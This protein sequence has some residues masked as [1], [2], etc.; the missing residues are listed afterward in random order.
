MSH[1]LALHTSLQLGDSPTSTPVALARLLVSKHQSLGKLK[2]QLLQVPELRDV[3]VP[4]RSCLRVRK[5]TNNARHASTIL[6]NDDMTL[7]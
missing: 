7:Q 6:R 3:G 5:L 4:C 1:V 2:T